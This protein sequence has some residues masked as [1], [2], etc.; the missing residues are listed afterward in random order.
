MIAS[1]V[2]FS[3]SEEPSYIQETERMKVSTVGDVAQARASQVRKARP[4]GGTRVGEGEKGEGHS[5][6]HLGEV[7]ST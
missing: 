4:R 1:Q 7:H 3:S 2:M 5:F 6:L